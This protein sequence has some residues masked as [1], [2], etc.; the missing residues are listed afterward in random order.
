MLKYIYAQQS[1]SVKPKH[2]LKLLQLTKI[3]IT[4]ALISNDIN[5]CWYKINITVLYIS[6]VIQ[7]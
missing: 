4:I 2:A 7:L 1:T 5:I 6:V 3:D